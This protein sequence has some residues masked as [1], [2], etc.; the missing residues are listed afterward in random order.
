MNWISVREKL[1]PTHRHVIVYRPDF[2]EPY[3]KV[4]GEVRSES[5]R[6]WVDCKEGKPLK[7]VTHWMPLPKTPRF[8]P[9]MWDAHQQAD[10]L[11]SKGHHYDS[12]DNDHEKGMKFMC[13]GWV[14]QYRLEQ[15]PFR[16][17]DDIPGHLAEMARKKCTNTPACHE[18]NKQPKDYCAKCWARRK[19]RIALEELHLDHLIKE[20]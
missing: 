9:S 15:I 7:G 18:S 11:M 4:L 2:D 16:L 3:D 10:D 5:T 17:L 1:P 12:M 6:E 13:A 20:D 8:P 14:L 19:A